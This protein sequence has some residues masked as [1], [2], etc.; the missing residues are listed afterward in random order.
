M[1]S[2]CGLSIAAVTRSVGRCRSPSCPEWIEAMTQSRS[3]RSSSPTSSSRRRGCST[4]MPSRIVSPATRSFMRVDRLVCF[5]RS[6]PS[7]SRSRGR[8]RRVL[9]APLLG[10]EA[11]HLLERSWPSDQSVC[12]CRSPLQVPELDQLRQP[13]VPR[14]VELAA[15]SRSSGGSAACGSPRRRARRWRTAGPRG[16]GTRAAPPSPAPAP[17]CPSRRS[18]SGRA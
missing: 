11:D 14:R 2:T 1:Q 7:R 17:R 6:A 16:S 3:A 4:S 5:P 13:T 15:V 8:R 12:V 18:A 9:V 10:C